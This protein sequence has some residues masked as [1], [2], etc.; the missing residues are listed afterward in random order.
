MQFKLK[1]IYIKINA[2]E[3]FIFKQNQVKYN[4]F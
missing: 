3:H 4:K 2:F 1:K